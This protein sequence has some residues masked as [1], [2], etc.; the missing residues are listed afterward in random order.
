VAPA[1]PGPAAPLAAAD[2]KDDAPSE[3]EVKAFERPVA[4]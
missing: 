3:D 2:K 1:G 4:K